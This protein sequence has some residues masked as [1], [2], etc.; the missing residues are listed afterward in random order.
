MPIS[1]VG[2]ASSRDTTQSLGFGK[3]KKDK[4]EKE[5]PIALPIRSVDPSLSAQL[6]P[7]YQG[8]MGV[9]STSICR[10]DFQPQYLWYLTPPRPPLVRG[11]EF[12][13]PAVR[14]NKGFTDLICA[15]GNRAYRKYLETALIKFGIDTKTKN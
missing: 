5:K 6:I 15:V 11:G 3:A 8:G 7:P 14:G 9:K 1:F 12:R 2:A 10:N 13:V 4:T